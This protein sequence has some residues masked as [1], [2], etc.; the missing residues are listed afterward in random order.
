V[1][2][3]PGVPEEDQGTE[4]DEDTGDGGDGEETGPESPSE[5]TEPS[6]Q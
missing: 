3:T 4:T 6:P 2:E 5:G 1:T